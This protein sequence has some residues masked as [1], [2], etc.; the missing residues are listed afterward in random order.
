MSLYLP[1]PVSLSQLDALNGPYFGGEWEV[2]LSH[3]A[4]HHLGTLVMTGADSATYFPNAATVLTPLVGEDIQI[5][6]IT[7][8]RSDAACVIT[9][10]GLD[11][12]GTMQ[13][14]QTAFNPPGWVGDQSFNFQRG[15]ANDLLAPDRFTS[16]TGLVGIT[17]GARNCAFDL[18]ALPESE[19]FVRVGCTSG[20]NFSDKSRQAR[21]I[22]CGVETDAFVKLGRTSPG[23]LEIEGKF[24]SPQEGLSRFSGDKVTCKLIGVKE[25]QVTGDVLVFTQ[26]VPNVSYSLP[27]GDDVVLVN[28]KGKFVELLMFSAPYVIPAAPDPGAGLSL[29]DAESGGGWTD[30]ESGGVFTT[31]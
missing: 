2:W 10:E 25:G 23:D 14:G 5:V 7:P 16:I 24:R 8:L 18:Y 20:V 15:V 30:P 6:C 31:P 1:D 22:D 11:T 12:T 4:S 13:S 19:S 17:N 21:G 29:T 26:F 28:C 9:F 3:D 27:D